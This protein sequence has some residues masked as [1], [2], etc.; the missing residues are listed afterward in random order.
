MQTDGTVP[1][2]QIKKLHLISL[3]SQLPSIEENIGFD[4]K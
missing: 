4:W 2:G 3:L 1:I